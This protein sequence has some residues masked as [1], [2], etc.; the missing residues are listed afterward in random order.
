MVGEEGALFP[1]TPEPDVTLLRHAAL[2]HRVFVTDALRRV[3]HV[4]AVTVEL[5]VGQFETPGMF[6]GY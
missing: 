2:Q 5:F 6:G 3:R 4:M 1:A